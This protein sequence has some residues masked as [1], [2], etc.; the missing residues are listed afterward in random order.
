MRLLTVNNLT[1]RYQNVEALRDVSF[2]VD[3]GD[4]LAIVGPNGSGK[5]TL[6]KTI[7]GLLD[8]DS[9]TISIHGNSG[10]KTLSESTGY[11]P[12]KMDNVDPRFPATVYEVVA[13][14]I[15][16]RKRVP[17]RLSHKDQQ[18]IDRVL[19]LLQID[20]LK[21]KTIGRLSGGQQQRTLLARALVSD[22]SILVLDEP[23][24]ALD[25]KSRD[26]FYEILKK[27]N[28]DYKKTILLV[29]HDSHS[30]GKYADRIL[31]LDRRVIF[32]G[33]FSEFEAALPEVRYFGNSDGCC[34]C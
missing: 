4:F 31:Y 3:T 15:L 19:A 13:T 8:H 2:H 5:T 23:T 24:G 25:P 11:L 18:E 34:G 26:H 6:V 21:R 33:S 30:F 1:V 14:G 22:P 9:G 10:R 32:F 12:Q 20:D 27:Y 17:R 16:S 7:L 28:N 29:T